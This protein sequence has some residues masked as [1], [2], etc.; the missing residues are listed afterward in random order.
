MFKF[1]IISLIVYLV[2][3]FIRGFFKGIIVITQIKKQQNQSAEK[4]QSPF[5]YQTNTRE[6][7][8]SER[9]RILEEDKNAE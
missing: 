6:K 8:I 2:F 9:A 3:K 1:L 5:Q 7:D 4:M